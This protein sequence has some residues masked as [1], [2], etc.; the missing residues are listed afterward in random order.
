MT[1]QEAIGWIETLFATPPGLVDVST[2][3]DQIEAWDSLGVLTLMAALDSDFGIQLSDEQIQQM[4]SVN[5]I[6]FVFRQN[7]VLS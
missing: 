3:R 6:L 7:G 1:Q 5:D 4:K 2:Q